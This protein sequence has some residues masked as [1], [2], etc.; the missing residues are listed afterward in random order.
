MI[1]EQPPPSPSN[2]D[3]KKLKWNDGLVSQGYYDLVCTPL[4]K[5]LNIE[6]GKIVNKIFWE[7]N[8][9]RILSKRNNF[10]SEVDNDE[11][12]Q[13]QIDECDFVIIALPLGVLKNRHKVSSL[14]FIPSL[15]LRK[16]EAIEAIGFGC[17]NKIILRFNIIFWEKKEPY[18]QTLDERFRILNGYYFGKG[19]TLVIHVSPPFGNGYNG[20]S[21]DQV[22]HECMTCIRGMYSQKIENDDDDEKDD[23]ENEEE[24]NNEKDEEDDVS[25]D[26]NDDNN[27][28]DDDDYE[29]EDNNNK[30]VKIDRKYAVQQKPPSPPTSKPFIV[31]DPIW[32]YVTRW[33][34][35]PF[36]MGAYS[37]WAQDM[38]L[39]HVTNIAAPEPEMNQSMSLLQQESKHVEDDGSSF[40]KKEPTTKPTTSL[41]TPRLYFCGEHAT[42]RDAQCVHGACNSG[43]R[44]A[45]QVACAALGHLEDLK[46]CIEYGENYW[47]DPPPPCHHSDGGDFKKVED[48]NDDD[49]AT[50][51]KK[52]KQ[53]LKKKKEV[54]PSKKRGRG[55]NHGNTTDI[56]KTGRKLLLDP[57]F[58]PFPTSDAV[59]WYE[60]GKWV[61]NC[62]CG[63]HKDNYDDGTEMVQ[64]DQCQSWQH[65]KCMKL[66]K[67]VLGIIDEEGKHENS[68]N[69]GGHENEENKGYH[70]FKCLHTDYFWNITLMTQKNKKKE[71]KNIL[72]KRNRESFQKEK[73]DDDEDIIIGSHDGIDRHIRKKDEKKEE[74]EEEEDH[75]EDDEMD[76]EEEEVDENGLIGL[77]DF[78]ETGWESDQDLITV[79]PT[80]EGGEGGGNIIRF[81]VIPA[82]KETKSPA[83]SVDIIATT[84][85]PSSD[86]V[87]AT[88]ETPS[89]V[90][91]IA[92][93]ETPSSVDVIATT[94]TPSSVDVIATT[95]TSMSPPSFFSD[96]SYTTTETSPSSS[97]DAITSKETLSFFNDITTMTSQ[98]TENS[99]SDMEEEEE[100]DKEEEMYCS[101]SNEQWNKWV[102]ESRSISAN[103]SRTAQIIMSNS[104]LLA[105]NMERME[106]LQQNRTNSIRENELDNFDDWS[107]HEVSH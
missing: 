4:S 97:F 107:N 13:Q 29:E 76:D 71:K 47:Y 96:D 75:D 98:D 53:K 64:C 91:V 33:N 73:E 70:C 85:T 81:K 1:N 42:I 30:G 59:K 92:T 50:M 34:E 48:E 28:N 16:L 39:S 8:K 10:K 18:L 20:L 35:D 80:Q 79:L 89:S 99:D 40:I 9:C 63:I 22:I 36:S 51:N 78:D 106:T 65:M 49:E 101:F 44:A 93:T 45:R 82:Q 84:E 66:Y 6:F 69:N 60:R 23:E 25:E 46:E 54:S 12:C 21:D 41:T 56:D 27:D 14:S 102:M 100:E 19:N 74:E 83:S 72:K 37:Y 58:S 5:G 11:E 55:P 52:K 26:N 88:T 2:V 61:F 67:N 3:E 57:Q 90:D 17:E 31:P 77:K 94:E 95:K 38:K 62:P 86:H 43:E 105:K 24:E 7:G 104:W 68:Q 103:L 15:P 32:T 87:I